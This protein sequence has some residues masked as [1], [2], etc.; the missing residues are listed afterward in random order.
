AADLSLRTAVEV[1]S[2]LHRT[3]RRAEARDFAVHDPDHALR[4]A[5]Q[6]AVLLEVRDRVLRENDSR[7]PEDRPAEPL[8]DRSRLD[9]DADAAV[10]LRM[11]VD[12]QARDRRPG[13]DAAGVLEVDAGEKRA[14]ATDRVAAQ[15]DGHAIDDRR[16]AVDDDR[17][18]DHPGAGGVR[19]HVWQRR[20]PDDRALL[21]A[22]HE[23]LPEDDLL[24]V[25]AGADEHLV[26]GFGRCDRSAD[27]PEGRALA[28]ESVVV[29]HEGKARVGTSC[30]ENERERDGRQPAATR[31][32]ALRTARGC[33]AGPTVSASTVAVQRLLASA[34]GSWNP[35]TTSRCPPVLVFICSF[36]PTDL[37][38]T[39]PS[40][41]VLIDMSRIPF[42]VVTSCFT[43]QNLNALCIFMKC[44]AG[45]FAQRRS[46]PPGG[47]ICTKT[48]SFIGFTLCIDVSAT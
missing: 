11:S 23:L 16:A 28:V 26:A 27:R 22:Q 3:G 20:R 30:R 9:V 47:R 39:V 15:V 19:T 29:D 36:F 7:T 44:D 38:R 5:R 46:E 2:V 14:A 33:R 24:G 34:L 10:A 12:L 40:L 45:S 31:H 41:R 42:A 37:M 35:I 21:P 25:A 43:S 6:D 48:S 1:E 4:A 18:R 13:H 8:A 32:G 17:G